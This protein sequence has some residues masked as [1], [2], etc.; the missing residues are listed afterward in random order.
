MLRS[1]IFWGRLHSLMIQELKSSKIDDNVKF[2]EFVV[3]RAT[4]Y[5]LMLGFRIEAKCECEPK[6][7]LHME[8]TAILE[9]NKGVIGQDLEVIDL[10]QVILLK[11]YPRK[12]LFVGA[13]EEIIS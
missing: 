2:Y 5:D 9:R 3:E 13:V 10:T 12:P 6:K 1:Q 4:E 11:D 7:L 8:G